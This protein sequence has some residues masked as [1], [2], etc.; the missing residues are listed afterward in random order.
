MKQL[1]HNFL[2]LEKKDKLSFFKLICYL[3]SE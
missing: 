3:S 1:I 2:E